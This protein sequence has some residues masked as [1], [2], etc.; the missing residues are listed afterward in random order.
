MDFQELERRFLEHLRQRVRGGELSERHLARITGVSQ[1]HIHNV[2]KGK[3]TLSPDTADLILH[4]LQ[5]DL[6]DFIHPDE[7]AQKRESE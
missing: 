5:L 6:L 4:I 7:L 3:R 1:P 2:L